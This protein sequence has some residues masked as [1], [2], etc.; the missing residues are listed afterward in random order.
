MNKFLIVFLLINRVLCDSI[1]SRNVQ[2]LALLENTMKIL[3]VVSEHRE[4]LEK[5]SWTET[6]RYLFQLKLTRVSTPIDE[7]INR[8][9]LILAILCLH[10][11]TNN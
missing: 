3:N 7:T 9:I 1:T 5:L 4:Q 11:I 2:P 10:K 6:T 8:I